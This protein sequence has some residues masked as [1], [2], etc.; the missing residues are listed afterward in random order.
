[1]FCSFKLISLVDKLIK[2]TPK[3]PQTAP[4]IKNAKTSEVKPRSGK[5]VWSINWT[6]SVLLSHFI[7]I[8]HQI[9][10]KAA[11]HMLLTI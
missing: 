4:S 9:E 2:K 5:L 3:S 7:P 10:Q 8:A 6:K 11:L 1:M